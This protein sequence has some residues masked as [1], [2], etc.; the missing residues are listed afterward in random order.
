MLN[1]R[2]YA[3]EREHPLLI[4]AMDHRD[5]LAKNVYGLGATP[6][7][8][9]AQQISTGKMEVFQ[10]VVAALK[11]L[12]P[13]GRPG[14]LVDERYGSDVARTARDNGFML[15]MPIERSGEKLFH[16]EYGSFD[17][18]EWL[19][20]LTLYEPDFAK[21]LVRDSFSFPDDQRRSQQD[22]LAH[23]T[24]RLQEIRIPLVI[25]LLV[26]DTGDAPEADFDAAIRPEM[27]VRLI[28][29]FHDHGVE[30]DVWKLE[31]YETSADAAEVA[32]TAREGDR[33]NVTCIIL[34]RD[35]PEARL[36]RWLKTA[37][38]V[39]GFTGFAI[40]R[41][42]WEKPLM[43]HLNERIDLTKM[44]RRISDAYAHYADVY[45]RASALGGK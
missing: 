37:A 12:P 44:S 10:G 6:S 31:G 28:R 25:E 23:V 3:Y 8:E 40:G 21:V 16:L 22:H 11:E 18:N 14:V 26:P 38:P 43:D 17:S 29:D 7:L 27:T 20:H 42:I 30:P 13:A 24:E 2:E 33:S 15:L 34:G 19:D 1:S 39:N 32:N 41:S 5:S 9:E 36:D 45:T 4:L 35:A